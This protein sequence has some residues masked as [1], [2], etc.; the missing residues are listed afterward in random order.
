MRAVF[1][2][3]TL[4]DIKDFDSDLMNELLTK[5]NI[6]HMRIFNRDNGGQV[7]IIDIENEQ[8]ESRI[9]DIIVRKFDERFKEI[10]RRQNI[11]TEYEKLTNEKFIL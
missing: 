6:D 3:G 11:F 10:E 4:G 8:L 5:Q 7:G 9:Q 1:K 2:D